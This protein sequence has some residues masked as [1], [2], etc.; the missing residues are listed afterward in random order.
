MIHDGKKKR[1]DVRKEGEEIH[2]FKIMAETL[3]DDNANSIQIA[4]S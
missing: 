1:K 4:I 2:L 3:E